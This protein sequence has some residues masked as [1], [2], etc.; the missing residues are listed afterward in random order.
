MKKSALFSAAGFI[1]LLIAF[2]AFRPAPS[3]SPAASVAIPDSLSV[4]FEKSCMGC[5]STDGNGMARSH[6]N[7]EKWNDYT[8]EKHASKAKDICKEL[9]KGAMPPASFRK[10]NPD[11]VPTEKE[12]KMICDWTASFNK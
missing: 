8:P 12:I 2:A 4:I 1:L 6:V 5:H 10:N 9:T 7:F 3:H 11:K